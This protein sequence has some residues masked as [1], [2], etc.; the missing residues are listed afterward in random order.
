MKQNILFLLICLLINQFVLTLQSVYK[1]V[2]V[3]PNWSVLRPSKLARMFPEDINP[4]LCT[5]IHYAYAN[6]NVRTLDLMPSLRQDVL[7]GEHGDVNKLYYTFF[8]VKL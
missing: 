5:H 8:Y 4:K 6:I 3:Y 7:N 2:C 1:R